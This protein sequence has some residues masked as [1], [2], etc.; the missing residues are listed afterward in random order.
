MITKLIITKN[1]YKIIY[2]K[3]LLKNKVEELFI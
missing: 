1:D 2:N 3:K